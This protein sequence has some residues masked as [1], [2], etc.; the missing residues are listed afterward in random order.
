MGVNDS[1][2]DFP[3]RQKGDIPRLFGSTVA[4]GES[5]PRGDQRFVDLKE[6]QRPKGSE[7][8]PTGGGLRSVKGHGEQNSG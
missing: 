3:R 6:F 2:R 8:V 4:D 5:C 7:W 1:T